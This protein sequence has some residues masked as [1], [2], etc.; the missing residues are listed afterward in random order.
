MCIR[1]SYRDRRIILQLYKNQRALISRD[2]PKANISKGCGLSSLLFDLYVGDAEKE[3]METSNNGILINGVHYK[4][5]RFA[6]DI[7]LLGNNGEELQ[8]AFH[9]MNKILKHMCDMPINKEKT[10]VM[11]RCRHGI[12]PVPHLCPYAFIFPDF[13]G[14]F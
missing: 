8:N 5:I 2:G 7:P 12:L 3:F 13:F 14:H 4:T 11:K 10:K 1:D 6:D 9:Q